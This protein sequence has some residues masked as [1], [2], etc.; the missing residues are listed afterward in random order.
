MLKT[1]DFATLQ[2]SGSADQDAYVN[3]W[4]DW[5]GEDGFGP[6][7]Q[8]VTDRLVNGDFS[9]QIVIAVPPDAAITGNAGTMLRARISSK[10]GLMP[11]G[12]APD[13]EVEDH[14]IKIMHG[15][16]FG[17]LPEERYTTIINSGLENDGPKHKI[18]G[19][20]LG[21]KIDHETDGF[22][23]KFSDITDEDELEDALEAAEAA[24]RIAPGRLD[25]GLVLANARLAAGRV[26][27]AT[28]LLVKLSET[29]PRSE[30]VHLVL[31]DM[32]SHASVSGQ[33]ALVDTFV[34]RLD[35]CRHPQLA[36][37]NILERGLV[38]A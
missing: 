6:G 2:V 9:E 22:T 29:H 38:R 25:V 26:E 31:T 24:Y 18:T 37:I 10:A 16:D 19:L 5:D 21:D 28:T 7:E 33:H 34:L 14:K 23:N 4:I 20:K 17:D 8:V 13:G 30:P 36:P 3:I 27:D 15:L 35:A 1:G 12:P 11:V 32:V